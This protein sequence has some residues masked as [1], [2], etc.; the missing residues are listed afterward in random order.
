VNDSA[1]DAVVLLRGASVSLGKGDLNTATSLSRKAFGL[2]SGA[3]EPNGKPSNPWRGTRTS[4]TEVA[5]VLD[6][7]KNNATETA[8]TPFLDARVLEK[9][10]RHL[11][12]FAWSGASRSQRFAGR[13]RVVAVCALAALA[14]SALVMGHR[15]EEWLSPA[16]IVVTYY[17]GT[18]FEHR[19]CRRSAAELS[20]DYD[21]RRPAFRVPAEGF[22]A[23][24]DGWLVAPAN[25]TYT[26][27][28]QSM[29]GIRVRIDGATVLDRWVDQEWEASRRRWDMQLTEGPHRIQVE[30]HSREGLAALTVRWMGGGVDKPTVLRAPFLRKHLERHGSE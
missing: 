16:G 4:D 21:G 27:F 8:K 24:W 29:D 25:D 14:V 3:P 12:P 23:R 30:H 17:R 11:L 19:I 7:W 18:Q 26:F 15:V 10:I 2:L 20:A 28:V 5:E 22:S 1:G 9:T 6:F 13:L